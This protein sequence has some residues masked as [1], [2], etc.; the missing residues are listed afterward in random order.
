MLD[1]LRFAVKQQT[2]GDMQLGWRST[3]PVV[4][5][6]KIGFRVVTAEHRFIGLWF[7]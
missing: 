7:F 6:G 2:T 5:A 1:G 4:G 3:R